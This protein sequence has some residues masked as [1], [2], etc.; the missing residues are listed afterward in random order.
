MPF[1]IGDDTLSLTMMICYV[2]SKAMQMKTPEL[3]ILINCQMS[4]VS[5]KY[6]MQRE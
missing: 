3:R 5:Q 1:S 6:K 2:T 4:Q